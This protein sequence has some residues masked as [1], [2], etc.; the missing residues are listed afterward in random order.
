MGVA[1]AGWYGARCSAVVWSTALQYSDG[2]DAPTLRRAAG[3]RE[4]GEGGDFAFGTC[5]V[6][7]RPVR[8]PFVCRYY[9]YV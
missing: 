8:A 9:L 5:A 4:R 7:G 2:D 6:C 1:G 3:A